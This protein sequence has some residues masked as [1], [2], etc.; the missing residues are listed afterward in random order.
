MRP[1][2]GVRTPSSTPWEWRRTAIPGVEFAQNAVGILPD[3]VAKKLMDNAGVDR[4][5]AL[6]ASH[7]RRAPRRHRV[8]ERRLRRRRP[9]PMPMMTMFDKQVSLRMGQCNV[10]RWTDDLLPLVEDPADPLGVMDL[11]THPCRWTERPRCTRLPEE[12]GR[13]HQ[14]R[15][16]ALTRP[17]TRIRRW[18]RPAVTR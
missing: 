11:V 18:S 4:L 17:V 16:E 10:Q 6:H 1:T 5:A 3:A 13:L 2:G 12:G 14:G 7:R 9:T 8:P 15:A